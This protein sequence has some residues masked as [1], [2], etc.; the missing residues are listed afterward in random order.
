MINTWNLFLCLTGDAYESAWSLQEGVYFSAT[1][2]SFYEQ[3]FP[4]NSVHVSFSSHGVMH[5]STRY[6]SPWLFVN[7]C[8]NL[9][10][11]NWLN[12]TCSD[13]DK[14]KLAIGDG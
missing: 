10:P 3:C 8:V 14:P 9:Q 5:L 1:G 12:L 4:N 2:C 11:Y 13:D 6:V 7:R